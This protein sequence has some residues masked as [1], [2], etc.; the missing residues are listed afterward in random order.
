M[1]GLRILQVVAV[2]ATLGCA[3]ALATPPGRLPLA[4]RGLQRMLRKDGAPPS[5]VPSPSAV[6]ATPVRRFLAFLLVVLAA[7]LAMV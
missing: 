6:R 7:A 3:A 1:A 5:A 2:I 4:L